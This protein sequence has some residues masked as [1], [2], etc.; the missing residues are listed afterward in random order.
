MI[1]YMHVIYL[2]TKMEDNIMREIYLH[3]K[4]EDNIRWLN[5]LHAMNM[6]KLCRRQAAPTATLGKDARR[7]F[8]ELSVRLL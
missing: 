4:L 5:Y 7:T 8:S 6:N 3:I 1:N 2:Y